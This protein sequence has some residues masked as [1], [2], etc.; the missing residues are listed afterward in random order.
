M[1]LYIHNIYYQYLIPKGLV[2]KQASIIG[3]IVGGESQGCVEAEG[4]GSIAVFRPVKL[5]GRPH[6]VR[7]AREDERDHILLHLHL[8]VELARHQSQVTGT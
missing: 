7:I 3:Q 1:L 4:V 8:Q 2:P 6:G 5:I